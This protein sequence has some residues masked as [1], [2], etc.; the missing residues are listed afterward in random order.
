MPSNQKDIKVTV[1][2]AAAGKPF[3]HD[4]EPTTPISEVLDAALAAFEITVDGTSRYYLLHDGAE[5]APTTTLAEVVG[6]ARAVHLRLRTETI[7]G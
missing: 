7:Q 4:Y 1:T 2:F 5:L 3:H 6:H